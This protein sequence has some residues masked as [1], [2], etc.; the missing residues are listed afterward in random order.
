MTYG[1]FIKKHNG[2]AWDY[3]GVP[4]SDKVQCVDLVKFYLRDCFGIRPGAWGN[5][6]DYFERFND[7]EW[8]GFSPMNRVFVRI[9]NTPDFVPQK[10][11]IC[12]WGAG[13]GKF[14]HIAIADGVGDTRHFYSYDQNWSGKKACTRVRHSYKGFLGVLRA[15]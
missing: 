4:V 7:R 10:G 9:K 15:K 2:T 14:G 3:D 5:A 12:V 8:Y 6:R 11:D 1:E 13:V